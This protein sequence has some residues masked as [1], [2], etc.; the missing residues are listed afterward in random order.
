MSDSSG[1]K[2]GDYL[3]FRQTEYQ[4][5]AIDYATGSIN[6]RNL[7]T[8]QVI[9]LSLP[10]IYLSPDPADQVLIAATLTELRAL[11]AHWQ[12]NPERQAIDE[13]DLPANLLK[14]ADQ[15][16]TTVDTVE[17]QLRAAERTAIQRGKSFQQTNYLKAL[18]P[19][20][21]PPISTATYYR[22]RKIYTANAGHRAMIAASLRR[23]TFNQTRMSAAQL[24][25]MAILIQRY[26]ARSFPLSGNAL[27][28]MGRS[29][30]QR[31]DG[32]WVD[33]DRC[34]NG[35][36]EALVDL[37]LNIN[38]P[39][40]QILKN[41]EYSP[42]LTQIEYPSRSWM[43]GYLKHCTYAE[44]G[45]AAIRIARYGQVASDQMSAVYDSHIHHAAYPL[46]YVFADHQLIDIYILGPDN[47]PERLWLTLLIDAFSRAVLGFVL[48][49]HGPSIWSIQTAL[50]HSI[51]PKTPDPNFG[52][53]CTFG[54]PV[55]LSLDN[56][57]AHH[58]KSLE[59]L[60][61]LLSLN[62][63]YTAMQLRFRPPYRA[64]YGALIERYFGFISDEIKAWLPGAIRRQTPECIRA[65]RAEARLNYD[66]L[67]TFIHG[68]VI[69]YQHRQHSGIGNMTPHEKWRLGLIE[70]GIPR[71]PNRTPETERIF[72]RMHH[73]PRTITEKGIALFGM[74]YW[75]AD[76]SGLPR[77]ERDGRQARYNIRYDPINISRLALFKDGYWVG[78]V[79]SKDLLEAD[80]SVTSL[81]LAELQLAKTLARSYGVPV[82]ELLQVADWRDKTDQQRVKEAK[83][84]KKSQSKPQ[85]ADDPPARST[86]DSSDKAAL[87]NRF[88]RKTKR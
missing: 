72:W 59:D 77:V 22:Y 73:E 1:L 13:R 15:I 44:D 34:P 45:G 81:S 68:T 83:Q 88:L 87:L 6:A 86:L 62:G 43:M 58:S 52:E 85:P 27:Y 11:I 20:L 24:H 25:L 79:L 84:R 71:I 29:I 75:N 63:T 66:D 4:I 54:I 78:D 33:P 19:K 51:W 55:E 48:L 82:Q 28:E 36:P 39:F 10:E 65:A 61:R 3:F 40:E 76:L 2:V 14:Q 21:D 5:D 35:V 64:R 18:L 74:H 50:G 31:T 16:I 56:A 42:L 53:W 80:G 41:S 12:P 69:R 26:Y 60:T 17:A 37:L 32:L 57:W 70:S 30:M 9:T 8:D 49:P 46:Q 7:I 38:I 67:Y 47:Q 23:T